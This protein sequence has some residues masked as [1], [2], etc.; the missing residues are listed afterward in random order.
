MCGYQYGGQNVMF[1]SLDAQNEHRPHGGGPA[2][3]LPVAD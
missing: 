1:V 3:P 2:A